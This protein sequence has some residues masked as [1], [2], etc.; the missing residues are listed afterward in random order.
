MDPLTLGIIGGG[1]YL[2]LKPR[3]PADRFTYRRR[4]GSWQAYFK[5][6]PPSY[7]HVLHDSKGYYV[8]W[9]QPLLSERAARQVATRWVQL[10][11]K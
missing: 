10:Y 9:N 4:R 5:S 6:T 1:L 8:C 11:G 7:S 3:K 2:L